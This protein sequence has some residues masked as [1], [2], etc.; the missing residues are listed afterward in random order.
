[1][2]LQPVNDPNV[3]AQLEQGSQQPAAGPQPVQDPAILA[4][5][6]GQ[7][8]PQQPPQQDDKAL[9]PWASAVV[10][11][12]AEGAGSLPMMAADAGVAAGHYANQGLSAM[13]LKTYPEL[14]MSLPSQRFKE[15]LDKYTSAPEGFIGK[16]AE[17]I[18]SMLFGGMA[19][20]EGIG[21]KLTGE[22]A[23]NSG[24]FGAKLYQQTPEGAGAVAGQGREAVIR[25][26][27]QAGFKLPPEGGTGATLASMT[28]KAKLERE[29]STHNDDRVQELVNM[30]LK[31]PEGHPLSYE[32]LDQI[33]A[34]EAA[35]YEKF[36]AVP[37]IKTDEE[38]MKDISQA[39][40]DF[41]K[42]D[43]AYPREPGEG[44]PPGGP[45]A[46][47]IEALKGRYFQPQ[48]SGRDMLGAIKQLRKDSG[49]NLK[50]YDPA[51]N[52]L[53]IVQ[54]QISDAFEERFA[55]FAEKEM[56]QPQL[57]SQLRAAR[58]KIAQTYAVQDAMNRATGRVSALDLARLYQNGAPLTGELQTIARA[59]LA[60][61]KAFK[62]TDKIGR[63]GPFSVVDFIVAAGGW[64]HNPSLLAAVV[65]RPAIRRL[66]QT[67]AAQAMSSPTIVGQTA[68]RSAPYA[69]PSAMQQG[70]STIQ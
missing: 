56:G 9:G 32:A 35:P 21:L 29:L 13:G 38:L 64:L 7:P 60:A 46:S 42:I 5:L 6:N 41:Q 16:G 53:G 68:E 57:A 37:Q 33:R 1:M 14:E 25:E 22:A 34:V 65:A 24:L 47:Q 19:N 18:S 36:A 70:P 51:K 66:L 17:M 58:V 49:T 11:P 3:V 61:P 15:A 62:S 4:Q 2:P 23:D 59:A 12:I 30:A 63:E 39:G 55:R 67:K 31:H 50:D 54:R 28:G 45:D 40:S 43:R 8:P 52:A 27:K 20:P 48:Q 26:A 10:R 44:P 69:A